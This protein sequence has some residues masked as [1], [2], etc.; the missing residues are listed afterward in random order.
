[1]RGLAYNSMGRTAA[2]MGVAWADFDG[3][4]L[5]DL[6]VTHLTEEFHSL[7]RQDRPGLF[8]DVAAQAGLQQQAWRGTGFGIVA[9]DFDND[10]HVDLALA[11][12]LV[13]H[14]MPPQSPV[15]AGTAPWWSV[16]AQRAQ[17]FANVGTGTFRDLSPENT[18]FC[19]QASVGRSLAVGDW[20]RDGGLD[21]V[22]GNV[23][24]PA[25]VFLNTV[26]GRGNWVQ[27]RL[28]DPTHGLRDEIGAEAS[29]VAG[30]RRQ[31]AVLQPA[32]SYLS[33]H[34]PVLHFGLGRSQNFD[35]VAVQWP[36]G[37]KESFLGGT[38]GQ[39]RVLRRG[40]G[41]VMKMEPR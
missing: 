30:G 37:S 7:Y 5:G 34:E 27:F 25:V 11:N 2:N 9:A 20:N 41:Q 10:G 35:V 19:G 8:T 28:V 33:S 21:L 12:G 24:G 23:A 4:A 22:L 32:T 39:R 6:F 38:G 36:D 40:S 1:M 16:Y 26:P 15:R 13:S 18:A 31:W 3:D 17:L 14:A 29:V